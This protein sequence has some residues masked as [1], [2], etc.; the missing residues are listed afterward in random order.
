MRRWTGVTG[1]L[2]GVTDISGDLDLLPTLFE[3]MLNEI[4]KSLHLL[5][6]TMPSGAWRRR[7]H[8]Q[9]P[10]FDDQ[11]MSRIVIFANLRAAKI[12]GS[13]SLDPNFFASLLLSGPVGDTLPSDCLL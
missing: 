10:R 2:S 3:K 4:W 13:S 7:S 1:H 11:N 9:R 6:E 8:L 5:L 12:D